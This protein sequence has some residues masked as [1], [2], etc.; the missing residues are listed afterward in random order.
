MDTFG[1]EEPVDLI[2]VSGKIKSLDQDIET[3]EA[4][5]LTMLNDLV[6]DDDVLDAVRDVFKK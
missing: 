1:A 2:A 3:N 4:E 6:G 5:L